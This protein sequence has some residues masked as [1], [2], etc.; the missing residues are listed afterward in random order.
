[1]RNL[2][3]VCVNVHNTEKKCKLA[4]LLENFVMHYCPLGHQSQN[5][6][7]MIE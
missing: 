2:T 3:C 4:L 1:M 5:K 6:S 7:Y